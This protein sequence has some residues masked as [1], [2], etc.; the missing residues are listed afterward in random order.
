LPDTTK[1]AAKDLRSYFANEI[2]RRRSNPGEDLIS[3]LVAAHDE[4]EALSADELL[5]F[6]LLLL[7][8]GNETTTN[9]IG[10]GMLALG[11]NPEQLKM[12]QRD[13]SLL[14]RAIEEMLRY[15]GPVQSTGASP[16]ATSN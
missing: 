3:A 16:K 8:A 6:V 5:A 15:D 10:N 12:L 4:T 13:T 9:L 14:P 1:Q 11:R 2:E 7:L